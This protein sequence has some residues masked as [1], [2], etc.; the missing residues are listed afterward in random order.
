MK[1]RL[2]KIES[3]HNNLR[4]DIVEGDLLYWPGVGESIIVTAKPLVEGGMRLV[5]TSP[6]SKIE[7]D[8]FHTL[9]SVYRLE[10]LDD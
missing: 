9:N 6:V 5:R 1:V 8:L 7:G 2:T 4:T 3:S 10:R